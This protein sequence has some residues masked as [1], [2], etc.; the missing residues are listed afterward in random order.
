MEIR[1]EKKLN[2][3]KTNINI[4]YLKTRFRDTIIT[5]IVEISRFNIQ[6]AKSNFGWFSIPREVFCVV[7]FLGSIAYNNKGKESGAST[8]KAVRFIKEFFPKHYKA[9]ANLII[10]IW[11]QG[12]VHNYFPKTIYLTQ[13]RKKIVMKWTSNRGNEDHNRRVNMQTFNKIGDKNIVFLSVNISQLADDLVIAIDN[14]TKKIDSNPSFGR[15]CLRRLNRSQKMQNYTSLRIGT[16]EKQIIKD[17]IRLAK[18]LTKGQMS[19]DL[20]V[21]WY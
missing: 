5:D 17:Q 1:E 19:S 3:M 15:A 12:T 13:G 7:D 2:R 9:L 6:D 4:D 16:T 14:F 11:R 18:A 20:Q 21:K 8:R 10:A